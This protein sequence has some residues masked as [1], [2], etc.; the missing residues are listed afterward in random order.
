MFYATISELSFYFALIKPKFG[1]QE[2][3]FE[4]I[5][6]TGSRDKSRSKDLI[7]EKQ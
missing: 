1:Q 7:A 3:H 6:C 5:K 2:I 4:D